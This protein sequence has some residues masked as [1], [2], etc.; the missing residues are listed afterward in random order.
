MVVLPGHEKSPMSFVRAYRRC[1]LGRT[2]YFHLNENVYN[3]GEL[4]RL[5]V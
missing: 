3:I 5:C 2:D 1:S 4:T